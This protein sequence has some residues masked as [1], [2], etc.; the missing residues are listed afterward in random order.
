M[1]IKASRVLTG[2][3]SPTKFLMPDEMEIIEDRVKIRQREWLGL[4]R[5]EEVISIDRIASVRIQFGLLKATVI[6]ETFGGS[7]SD[8]RIDSIG[9]RQ[10]REFRE[11]IQNRVAER[12]L[13]QPAQVED[14]RP[15]SL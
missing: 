3:R 9:K 5:E 8:L 2:W 6:L 10:A 15:P 13:P 12:D 11:S 14:N 1:K 4:R 7:T